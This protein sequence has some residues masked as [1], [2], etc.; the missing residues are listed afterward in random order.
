MA[1]LRRLFDRRGVA[2][3]IVTTRSVITDGEEA[4]CTILAIEANTP[5]DRDSV[6][7]FLYARAS[8][9]PRLYVTRHGLDA[10]EQSLRD[11]FWAHTPP[12]P[13]SVVPVAE[14]LRLRY[15]RA[16]DDGPSLSQ[17]CEG[18]LAYVSC[19]RRCDDPLLLCG[20]QA[21]LRRDFGP[22]LEYDAGLEA[23][24]TYG[25]GQQEV[26]LDALWSC[27]QRLRWC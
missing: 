9:D 14:T 16:R 6:L 20:A 22:F 15:A 7:R 23:C 24:D 1:E 12:H 26:V 17:L 25:T 11:A 10:P 19:L 5:Q 21:M 2:S 8:A 4:R 13:G 3:L 18:M 27:M